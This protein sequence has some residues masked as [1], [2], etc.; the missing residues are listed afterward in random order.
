LGELVAQAA[1]LLMPVWEELIRQAAQV[2]IDLSKQ[3]AGLEGRCLTG[4]ALVPTSA[5]LCAS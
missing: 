2:E 1:Q 4:Q 5:K 3:L